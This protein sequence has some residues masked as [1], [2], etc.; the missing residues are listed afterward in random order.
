MQKT[1]DAPIP[2]P[3]V[4]RGAS[5]TLKDQ[6]PRDQWYYRDLQGKVRGPFPKAALLK[7][8][9]QC[10]LDP[11][12]LPVSRKIRGPFEL[13]QDAIPASRQP[14]EPEEPLELEHILWR[15]FFENQVDGVYRAREETPQGDVQETKGL[16]ACTLN[17]Q[18]AKPKVQKVMR[19]AEDTPEGTGEGDF[20]RVVLPLMLKRIVS[21]GNRVERDSRLVKLPHLIDFE[22]FIDDT[23]QPGGP[24]K[25]RLHAIVCHL[26]EQVTSGHYVAL[27]RDSGGW[28]HFDDSRP[29]ER[30]RWIQTLDEAAGVNPERDA[31]L[32]VYE[33]C[34]SDHEIAIELDAGLVGTKPFPRPNAFWDAL[35]DVDAPAQ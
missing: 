16:V 5:G 1:T 31:Y 23:A 28:L 26:G 12:T 7:W 30:V 24:S 33:A 19:D 21:D 15:Y 2:R 6:R 11:A 29:T 20:P 18:W 9:E 35:E 27:V 10:L 25:L 34:L 17:L 8:A 3:G 32:L 4:A 14:A 13:M 22:H